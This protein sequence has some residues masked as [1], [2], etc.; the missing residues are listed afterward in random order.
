MMQGVVTAAREA[1]L[2]LIVR[3]ADGQNLPVEAVIDTGP[4][5]PCAVRKA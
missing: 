2:S 1:I 5:T 3:D 4:Y